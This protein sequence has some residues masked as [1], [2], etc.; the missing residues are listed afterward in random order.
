MEKLEKN[1]LFETSVSQPL[2]NDFKIK[3]EWV[4]C[5][6]D[7]ESFFLFLQDCDGFWCT[8]T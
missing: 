4:A 7:E 5:F 2:G 3:K 8:S 6:D 1:E